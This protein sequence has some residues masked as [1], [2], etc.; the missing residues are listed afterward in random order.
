MMN[1]Q[2]PSDLLA[3]KTILVTGAGAGIGRQAAITY[4]QHG[5]TVIL[6]GKTV[7]KLEAV[8][9][10]I[11]ANGS[12][13]PAIIPL[14]MK[15]ATKQ[16]YQDMARTIGDQFGHLDGVLLNAAALGVLSP[17][18]HIN[19]STWNEVMH[20]NVTAHFL[21]VQALLPI[22][23]KA[24]EASVVFTSSG[25]VIRA[26]AFWGAYAASKWASDAMMQT[27][28]DEFEQST[29]RFN[30]INPGPTDT[31]MRSRAYPGE[32]KNK[33]AKPADLMPCYLY[34]M[35]KDSAHL[36]GETL[37]AQSKDVYK[38]YLLQS[39]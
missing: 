17:F 36:N 7:K 13:E 19:E 22:L 29:L 26:K 23:K 12:P 20:V 10:E 37:Q 30:S 34:I 31:P 15:G 25:V 3:N 18:D 16:N 14:D 27:L 39:E 6:L 9:D 32:D 35:G 1:Y 28:A 38:D 8:Y 2:A 4:A 33:I 11:V 5:A 21:M 24:P